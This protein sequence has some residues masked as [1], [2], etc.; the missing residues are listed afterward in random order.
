M[1][2]KTSRRSLKKV[3]ILSIALIVFLGMTATG[4]TTFF[5]SSRIVR[6]LAEGSIASDLNSIESAIQITYDDNLSRQRETM[7]RVSPRVLPHL[8]IAQNESVEQNVEDQVS[9]EKSVKMVPVVYWKGKK[10]TSHEIVDTFAEESGSATTLFVKVEGGLLRATTSLKK[11]NGERAVG[12]M[13]PASSPVYKSLIRGESYFGRA[14]VLGEWY[15]TAYQPIRSGNETV[16]ALFVGSKETSYAKI[17]EYM[18]ARRILQTGYFFILDSKGDL[19]LHP[20]LEGKNVLA[21]TDV[22]GQPIFKQI[23]EKKK[24]IIE[25]RWLNAET[26]KVQ[27]KIAVF[28]YFPS[29]DWYVATSLNLDEA[30]APVA[31]L[32]NAVLLTTLG[33]ILVISLV[34]GWIASRTARE[35]DG[36]VNQLTGN[37]RNLSTNS[38]RLHE[39]SQ[40]LADAAADQAAAVQ[41]TA[42]AVE[43]VTATIERNVET[44]RAFQTYSEETHHAVENGFEV[45]VRLKEN[46][47]RMTESN[48]EVQNVIRDSYKDIR[49]ISQ[50]MKSIEEK[51]KIIHTIVFQTKLLSFNA[52]VEAARAGEHGKG[53]SVVA[54]EMVS[55]AGLT[56]QAATEI[57]QTI[58]HGVQK[59]NS[60]I[61]SSASRTQASFESASEK[62]RLSVESSNEGRESL[63]QIRENASRLAEAMASISTASQEQASAIGEIGKAIHKFDETTQSTSEQAKHAETI[64]VVL[65]TEVEGLIS[66]STT[67]SQIVHGSRSE[68]P[69][70]TITEIKPGDGAAGKLKRAS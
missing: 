32:K 38:D 11:A 5:L 13:I 18:K 53:F 54:A 17:K 56:G 55:L 27:N 39:A 23:L 33:A 48:S 67:L 68:T 21:K 3:L 50:V 59:V 42:A 45:M 49:A 34:V 29:M 51:T 26:Q 36:I 61:E 58:L 4:V 12:T 65:A 8:E 43:Q 22:D 25:Y 24:G 19:V 66:T 15:I 2:M 52:S 10:L 63:N 64:S 37:S 41:Q 62:V 44:T 9:H 30:L 6:G 16:G 69:K 40:R 14:Q 46:M 47:E 57:D 60:V 28:N 1:R 20:S 35:L 70:A 31:V 7:E